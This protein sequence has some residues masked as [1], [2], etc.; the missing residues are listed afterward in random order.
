[1][2]AAP[3]LPGGRSALFPAYWADQLWHEQRAAGRARL[4]L[5]P[6]DWQQHGRANSRPLTDEH[7]AALREGLQKY[8]ERRRK[9]GT[10]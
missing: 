2:S 7:K 6:R 9:G 8:W 3:P 10:G 1:M 5:V 4:M